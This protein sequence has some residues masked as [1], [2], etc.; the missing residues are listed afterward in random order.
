MRVALVLLGV[1]TAV[2]ALDAVAFGG[3]YRQAA[4]DE[5]KRQD[6]QIDYEIQYWMRRATR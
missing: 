5:A 6:T 1:L 4:W 3:R 2:L